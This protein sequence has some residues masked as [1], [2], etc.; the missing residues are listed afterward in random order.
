MSIHERIIQPPITS[1]LL[2]ASEIRRALSVLTTPGQVTELRILSARTADSPR[3]AYQASGYFNNPDLLLA[4][5]AQLRSAKGVYMTLHP[6]N[7][8]LLARAH[9]RLRTADQ[10]PKPAATSDQ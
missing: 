1:A 9:N 7:P 6:C 8:A 4:S 2:D 3:Y 10:M 5:L